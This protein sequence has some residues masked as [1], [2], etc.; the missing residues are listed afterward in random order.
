MAKLTNKQKYELSILGW[1]ADKPFNDKDVQVFFER[2][3]KGL[4]KSVKWEDNPVMVAKVRRDIQ[5]KYWMEDWG[6]TL[7]AWSFIDEPQHIAEWVAKTLDRE[8]V[9]MAWHEHRYRWWN[10]S[11]W[12]H[13]KLALHYRGIIDKKPFNK[14][15]EV[16]R[17][18]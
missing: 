5:V 1:F 9:I 7:N 11:S 4:H 18:G 2:S 8:A 10:P 12:Q 16:R 3:T 15:L 17:S 6:D 14:P 13:K